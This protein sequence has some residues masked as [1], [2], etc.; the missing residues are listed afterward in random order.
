MTPVEYASYD[1]T[2][3]AALVRSKAVS[4]DE[5]LDAA[6]ERIEALNPALNAVVH[7]FIDQGRAAIRQGLPSGPFE[8]VPYLIKNTGLAV[9]GTPLTTGSALFRD[10]VSP[11]DGTLTQRMRQAGLVI[12]GKTNVPEM[13]MSFTTEPKA[14]GVT[15]NPWNQGHGP[16]G[17]S[18]GSAAAVASGIVPMA[19]ASDGAGSTRLPAAH[20]G[21]FGMKPSRMRLPFGPVAAEGIAGMS[22]P[23]CLSWSVRDCA[24]M[25]DATHG[26][27]VGDPYAA[28]P[29]TGPFLDAV[30]RAP[31]RLRIGF[32]TVSPVGTPVDPACVAATEAA[33]ALCE[34]LGHHVEPATPGYDAARLKGAW[35][36]ISAASVSM[37][38]AARAA[39]L[40]ITEWRALVEP[41]NAE[42]AD[43]GSRLSA[44]TYAEAIAALQATSRAM[45]A[46]FTRYDI[47][48]SP[49]TGETAPKLGVLADRGDGLDAFYDRFWQHGPFTAV[50]NASGCPAMTVPFGL[51]PAGLPVGVQM[52]AAFGAETTLFA[53]AGQIEAAKPWFRC[54]PP[55][56]EPTQKI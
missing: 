49:T 21:L 34:S 4:A 5:V 10:N 50:F 27:D 45:G 20:C 42:W 53:L 11:A 31:G 56:K 19:H 37:Q 38:V 32:T 13:A 36:V 7:P 48:L 15:R 33:A 52:G 2:G 6:V 17:S 40:G 8:G 46:F 23:H 44:A 26:P 35:R 1:A 41:V 28:P 3:L 29:V 47:Y 18:G 9:A 39:A 12:I 30:T 51:S 24:G 54:R 55:A 22:G 43:E 25:L 16:G 14:F